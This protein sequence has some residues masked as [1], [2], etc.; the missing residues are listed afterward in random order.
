MRKF[1]KLKSMCTVVDTEGRV[2]FALD[3]DGKKYKPRIFGTTATL[4]MYETV[5][6][7]ND[8]GRLTWEEI[9]EK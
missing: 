2:L 3:L 5:R 4:Y 9:T 6:K 1:R 8:L 7:Y